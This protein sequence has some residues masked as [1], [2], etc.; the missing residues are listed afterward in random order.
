[1]MKIGRAAGALFL[2]SAAP[3]LAQ[4]AVNDGS[5]RERERSSY[6]AE[7]TTPLAASATFTGATRDAGASPSQWSSFTCF[8][9]S[10]QASASAGFKVQESTDGTNWI[11]VITASTAAGPATISSQIFARYGRCILVNGATANGGA[12]TIW[13]RFGAN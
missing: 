12:P 13:S 6:F 10:D 11:T 5:V 9:Y 2:L 1:M 8:G 4:A 3:L 7:T